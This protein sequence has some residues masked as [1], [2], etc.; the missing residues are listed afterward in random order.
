MSLQGHPISDCDVEKR[1]LQDL[2]LSQ[3]DLRIIRCSQLF[4]LSLEFRHLVQEPGALC[5]GLC[6]EIPGPLLQLH[7]PLQH[8]HEDLLHCLL[9]VHL[10]HDALPPQGHPRQGEG[11]VIILSFFALQSLPDYSSSSSHRI[12]ADSNSCSH[13][14]FSWLLSPPMSTR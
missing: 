1:L 9:R 14:V 6:D 8:G 10:L 11:G 4:P 3:L 2:P 13:P 7:L 5:P 12:P